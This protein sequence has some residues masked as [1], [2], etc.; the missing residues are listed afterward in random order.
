MFSPVHASAELKRKYY[1]Y[2]RTVFRFQ[3][4]DYQKQFEERLT[5]TDTL[6]SGPYLDVTDSFEKGKSIE[7]LIEEGVLSDGFRRLSLPLTRPLYRHQINAID[8][9]RSGHNLIV[10][11][12]TGS[13]KTESFLIPI[14]DELLREHKAGTLCPGVRA[15]LIYPMNALANDQTERLRSLLADYPEITYGSYTGQTKHHYKDALVNYMQLNNNEKPLPNELICRDQMKQTPPHLLITNYAMLE[16][17]MLRPED[18]VFFDEKHAPFWKYIVLDE[19]HVYHGGSGIEV[20]MLLRRLKSTLCKSDI[21][22]ILTSATL[23]DE[24]AN[25]AVAE[26][27]R[28]LCD[29]AFTSSDIVRSCRTVPQPEKNIAPLSL[30]VYE[31]IRD[32]L[33]HNN[34]QGLLTLLEL[35]GVNEGTVSERLYQ[36]ILHDSNYHIIRAELQNAPC[37]MQHLRKTLRWTESQIEAFVAAASKAERN[38][39]RLFDARYHMFLRATESAFVTLAPNKK[40]FLTRKTEHTEPDG[41]KFAVFEA[42]VCNHCH[43]LFLI[44]AEKEHRL[45]QS[46]YWTENEL[47]HVFLLGDSVS[48]SDDELSLLDADTETEQ[49]EVCAYCGFLRKSGQVHPPRCEHGEAAM[50]KLVSAHVTGGAHALTKCP[51]CEHSNST[52]VLR[53]FFTGQEAVTSVLGTALF[54]ELP[55][56]R[57]T[58]RNNTEEE[59]EFGFGFGAEQQ[60]QTA[61]AKQF[62]AFSDNRQA[63]AY[64][65]SYFDQTYRNVLYKRLIVETLREQPERWSGSMIPDFTDSLAAQFSLHGIGGTT[66]EQV[67]REAWKAL[68][69]E[70]FDQNGTT[71]LFNMGLFRFSFPPELIPGNPKMGLS[72]E[73]LCTL[74]NVFAASMMTNA[75]LATDYAMPPSEKEFYTHNG[76]EY[77]YTLSDSDAKKFRLSFIPRRSDGANKRSDY[78]AKVLKSV[79]YSVDSQEKLNRILESI[80]NGI[81]MRLALVRA[82]NSAYKLDSSKIR[83]VRPQKLFLCP[84]CRTLTPHNLNGVCPTY[85]CDGSLVSADPEALFADNHY[86]RLYQDMDIRQLRV[87]EHTAQLNRETAYDFQKRF[88]QKQIDVL[89]CSTTFEMG[90]DVGSLETVFMRNMPPS[91]ANYAQRAGRAGRSRDSAAFA[92]TFCNKSNH[93]FSYFRDPV[94]M[95]RGKIDPPKFNIENDKIAI[96]HVFASA[97]AYFWRLHPDYFSGAAIMVEEQDQIQNGAALFSAY[98]REKPDDL[99]AFLLRFLP[100]KLSDEFGVSDFRWI[101]RLIGTDPD[102]PGVLTKAA[103]EY[104]Y[105]IGILEEARQSLSAAK[106]H[107][108]YLI[109]RLATYRN[110]DILSYFSRANV[111]PKYGFPVDTVELRVTG[112]KDRGKLGLELQRD[113]S[114]AISEYAPGSQVVANGRLITSRYIRKVPKMNWKMYD[115]IRCDCKTLN[116]AVHTGEQNGLE[117]CR[118]CGKPLSAYHRTFL[119]PQFGFECDG[120]LNQRPGLKKPE[121]TYRGDISYVGYRTDTDHIPV[122]IGDSSLE[123]LVSR[124][125]E[126]AMINESGF[127][128]CNACGFTVLDEK[129]AQSYI[130]RK[131]QKHKNTS[132]WECRND[133]LYL[134][135]LGYRFQTDVVQIHF[136]QPVLD[137]WLTALSLLYGI[138]RGMCSCLNIE[139][140]DISGCVQYY[141]ETD[142]DLPHFALILYDRTPGGAGHVRRLKDAGVMEAVLRETLDSMCRCTCGGPEGDSSCYSCL[143]NYYNQKYHDD[144]KRSLVIDYLKGVLDHSNRD[145]P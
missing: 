56:Y 106:K 142:S 133:Q 101:D 121:R 131:T 28:N 141:Q 124:G 137:D 78:L 111:L 29:C 82:V 109:D 16:Y 118:S 46:S 10:S 123:L 103:E 52:G 135:S 55:A 92:V 11:T 95:I 34:E 132:G 72:A 74:C 42:A 43:A 51:A 100:E 47:N 90:V 60:E 19:A 61:E 48:D 73:Q 68:L 94:S 134:Y 27:G 9:L 85:H 66:A 38:G 49:Y 40:L 50:V 2:L 96:R 20:A 7:E 104:N 93:D 120:E 144:L 107:T 65:A 88:K 127:Y 26:F 83:I 45:V 37:T 116:I 33:D 128:V 18:N 84:K 97:L 24:Q 80:W 54:E 57:I 64:Y 67:T 70:L 30:S 25:E 138:L 122:I 108:D 110:E 129:N 8:K 115:Y 44:G 21:R 12:G 13:G 69:L 62:I 89:S 130:R 36:L 91:P 17:L 5:D 75:A 112:P 145:L 102:D 76:A 79:G 59:D 1:R 22:Y 32:H 77:S 113:L 63:A 117:T 81:F 6:A 41:T 114:L 126:M 139:Q 99:K 87:V 86:Y 119:V 23:G 53:K 143:R 14:L 125:D 35:L 98:L 140:N 39:D 3:D 4:A 136:D 105:E 31:Q 15:L 71:S 58:L